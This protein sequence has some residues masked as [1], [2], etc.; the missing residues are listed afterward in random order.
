MLKR[1]HRSSTSIIRSSAQR[2]FSANNEH[3]LA[4]VRCSTAM[5]RFG[6][7]SSRIP[8]YLKVYTRLMTSPSNTNFWHKS[9]K[10]NTMTFGFFTFTIKSTSVQNCWSAFN[11]YYSPTSDSDVKA[12]SYAKRKSHTCTSA[13]AGASCSL[14][15][16]RPSRASKYGLNSRG[17]RRQPCFT[18]YW[19]LKLEMTP[20]LGWLVHTIPLA[21]I[22]CRHRKKCPSTSRLANTCHNTSHGTISNIFLKSTKQQ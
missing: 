3:L 4:I 7:V 22:A 17:L 1:S 5:F 19:H 9:T 14:L 10:L 20:S 21:Y 12:R 15:S 8:R 13:K 16:I 6:V 11:Y 2:W 18:P